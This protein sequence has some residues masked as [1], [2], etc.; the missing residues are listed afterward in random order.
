MHQV[1]QQSF[2]DGIQKMNMDYPVFIPEK[3]EDST[4]FKFIEKNNWKPEDA[5]ISPIRTAQPLKSF[6]VRRSFL[7]LWIR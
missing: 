3:A 2:W 4:N 5:Y 1:S 6:L 7:N